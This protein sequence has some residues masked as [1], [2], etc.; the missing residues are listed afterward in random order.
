MLPN[1]GGL[2]VECL[3]MAPAYKRN[4][5]CLPCDYH[6]PTRAIITGL[7]MAFVSNY[8]LANFAGA[9]TE[10]FWLDFEAGVGCS[11]SKSVLQHF[12]L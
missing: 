6:N 7:F 10:K 2:A 8:T 11:G 1:A 3:V 9:S 12:F 4:S 5:T